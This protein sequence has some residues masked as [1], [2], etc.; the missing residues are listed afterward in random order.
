MIFKIT[1]ADVN[2]ANNKHYV[3]ATSAIDA[4]VIKDSIVEIWV[5]SEKFSFANTMDI[6]NLLTTILPPFL[7]TPDNVGVPPTYNVYVSINKFGFLRNPVGDPTIFE[8]KIGNSFAYL[9]ILVP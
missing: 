6:V 2:G 8:M 9:P 3:I 4:Y 5:G 7:R 1:T